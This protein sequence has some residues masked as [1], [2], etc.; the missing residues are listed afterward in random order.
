MKSLQTLTVSI[1]VSCAVFA[2]TPAQTQTT[3]DQTMIEASRLR[4][5]G[6]LQEAEVLLRSTLAE[7]QQSKTPGILTANLMNQL[8]IILQDEG[9]FPEAEVSFRQATA[10]LQK[11]LEPQNPQ[12]AMALANLGSLLSEE[13]RYQEAYSLIRKALD[14]AMPALGDCHPKVALM[15]SGLGRLFYRQGE[16]TRALPNA[17]RALY[18]LEKQGAETV[19]LGED[20]Q[21]LAVMYLDD[22]QYSLAQEHLDRANAIWARLVPPDHPNVLY[23]R[24][25]QVT[26]YYKQGRY[27]EAR[28]L[29]LPLVEQARKKLGPKHPSVAVMLANIGLSDQKLRLYP[30]AAECF[31]E[32]IAIEEAVN[33]GD[34][35]LAQLLSS[36]AAV[37]RQEHRKPEAKQLELRAKTILANSVR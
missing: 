6:R 33:A 29:G 10:D 19:E 36:Y 27:Q 37:L 30:E 5:A 7:S 1:A 34:S 18:C 3:A 31:R 17:R 4:G 16:I 28:E 13:G 35:Y 2:G 32:A 11:L 23:G 14:I 22:G 20:N 12:I 26:L 8:G 25:T 21:N 15:Y 9:R 24:N